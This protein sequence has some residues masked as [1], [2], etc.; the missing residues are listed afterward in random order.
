MVCF[1][2]IRMKTDSEEAPDETTTSYPDAPP[3]IHGSME[4]Y[5]TLQ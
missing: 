2:A 1:S 3:V 5:V 4:Q